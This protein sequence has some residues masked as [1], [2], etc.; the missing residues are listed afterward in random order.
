MT[1]SDKEKLISEMYSMLNKHWME[2]LNQFE[3]KA[4]NYEEYQK[5]SF[6]PSAIQKLTTVI[7]NF[8]GLNYYD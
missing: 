1:I 6:P 5:T 2:N 7:R 4:I 3:A 8:E